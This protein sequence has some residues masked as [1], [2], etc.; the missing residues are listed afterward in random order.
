MTDAYDY[1]IK[2]PGV[3]NDTAYPYV[4]KQNT[5]CKYVATTNAGKVASYAYTKQDDEADL[6]AKLA[7][8]GPIAVA[9]DGIKQINVIQYYSNHQY[10]TI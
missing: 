3:A 4:A 8:I 5:A 7:T 1:S 9:I 10:V 6:K 2:N